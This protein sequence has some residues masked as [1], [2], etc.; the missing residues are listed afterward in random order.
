MAGFFVL[1]F[2]YNWYNF[3]LILI[4]MQYALIVY[5]IMNNDSILTKK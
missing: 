1:Y 4:S 5:N 2:V 3:A